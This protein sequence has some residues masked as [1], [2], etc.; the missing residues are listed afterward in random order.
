MWSDAARRVLPQSRYAALLVSL[1]GTGLYGRRDLAAEPPEAATAI[2]AFLADQRAWQEEI[3]AGLRVDQAAV[4]RHQRLVAVWDRLALLLCGGPREP[5][6]IEGVPAAE[7]EATLALTPAAGDPARVTV[8]PWPFGPATV[9]LVCEGRRLPDAFTD[10]ATMRAALAR[11]PWVRLEI[12]L[13][14]G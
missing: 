7:D 12:T 6:T 5:R 11:A 13:T 1:H 9:R 4:A 3:L 8:T 10:E 2:R 14:P